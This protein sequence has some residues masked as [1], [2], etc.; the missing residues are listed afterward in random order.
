MAATC[1]NKK[2]ANNRY[3]KSEILQANKYK[4]TWNV[5]DAKTNQARIN[6]LLIHSLKSNYPL[7][8]VL[9]LLQPVIHGG[10]YPKD[11]IKRMGV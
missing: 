4:K 1:N 11:I 8:G 10:L 5:R 7:H 3:N 6:L 2:Q 9:F